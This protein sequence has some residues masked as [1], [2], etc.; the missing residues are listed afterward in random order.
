[1]PFIT[2]EIWQSL[3]HEGDSIMVAKFP[4]SNPSQ[5]DEGAECS[6]DILMEIVRSIRNLRAELGVALGKKVE[7]T[8][9]PT[10][11][12]SRISVEAGV[13]MLES[14][15]KVSKLSIASER[16][17]EDAGQFV[18]AHIP[19]VDVYLPMAGLVDVDKELARIANELA[20]VEK[21]LAR[22]EGKLSNEK[23]TS[24]APAPIIEKERRIVRELTDKR[25]K[26][27]DRM[28]ALRG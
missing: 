11:D 5:I 13:R 17:S 1:M 22:S 20:D 15:G 7:A 9:V 3:P 23:F 27:Q 25:D 12:E 6:M 16:P 19:G 28:K 18:S 2:E 26:L 21:E 4:E 14:L 10:T 8:V 24:R